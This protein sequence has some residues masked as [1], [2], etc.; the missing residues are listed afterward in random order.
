MSKQPLLDVQD[1]RIAFRTERGMAEAVSGLSLQLSAGETLGL[2]GESG[3]GKSV[4]AMSLLRLLPQPASQILGGKVTFDGRDLLQIPVEAMQAVRGRRIAMIFQEPMAALN[5]VHS[6]G[7]QIEEVFRLH[8]PDLSETERRQR[9]VKLLK[10]VGI[11]APEQRVYDFPHQLS[12]GMRQRVMIAMAL[13][14]EPQVLIADEP[15]TALDVTIQAQ[16]LAL[17][18]ELQR[19]NGMSVI[20]ITHDLGVVGAICEN[21]AVM[22]A[23]QI[24]EQGVT[25]EVFARPRHPYTIGLLHSIPRLD[26]PGKQALLAI[27]GNVPSLH[28]WPMGCRFSNR[29]RHVAAICATPQVLQSDPADH[30]HVRC[31]RWQELGV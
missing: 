14:G 3:C 9:V 22:Y 6:V 15:T 30:R 28:E 20:M 23:G 18:A 16:I 4:T 24:V 17:L 21:I 10:R 11:P 8:F 31:G 19:E 27:D 26:A 13:A 1:L 29:C 5:P 25:R 7:R 2:V 12:G